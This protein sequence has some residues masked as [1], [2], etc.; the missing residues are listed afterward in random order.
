MG[1]PKG[2]PRW[3][4]WFLFRGQAFPR[5]ETNLNIKSKDYGGW[6]CLCMQ[7]YCHV[8]SIIHKC[9]LWCVQLRG[10]ELQGTYTTFWGEMRVYHNPLPLTWGLVSKH[11]YATGICTNKASDCVAVGFARRTYTCCKRFVCGRLY[12]LALIYSWFGWKCNA[13]RCVW[14]WTR[15]AGT[16]FHLA[17][18]CL[19]VHRSRDASA[20]KMV[21]LGTPTRAGLQGL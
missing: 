13:T 16:T 1:R 17:N 5:I 10:N 7:I 6:L 3:L 19:E 21:I 18:S 4:Y 20:K 8:Y 15:H 14:R 2:K 11:L 9:V 12:S